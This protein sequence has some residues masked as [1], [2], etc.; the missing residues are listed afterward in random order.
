[1]ENQ[2]VPESRPRAEPSRNG[3]GWKSLSD[4][5]NFSLSEELNAEIENLK[6]WLW[7]TIDPRSP[8][9]VQNG[10]RYVQARVT[11]CLKFICESAP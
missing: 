11:Y 6:P 5:S 4:L 7:Y 8:G 10:A 2:L 3:S 1:M 9:A